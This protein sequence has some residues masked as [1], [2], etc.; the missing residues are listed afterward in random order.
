MTDIT[1]LE[2]SALLDTA[3]ARAGGSEAKL[4]VAIGYSQVAVNKAVRAG[5]ATP[6]IAAA[7]HKWSGGDIPADK[8]CPDFPWPT[9][10]SAVAS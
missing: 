9:P 2:P 8:L 4:A 6:G 1:A 7:I 3:I 10:T 5:R